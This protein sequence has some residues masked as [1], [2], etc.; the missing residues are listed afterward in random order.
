MAVNLM[1]DDPHYLVENVL[2]PARERFFQDKDGH[3]RFTSY[4]FGVVKLKEDGLKI[5]EEAIEEV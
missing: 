4:S 3:W 2:E 5:L 1:K